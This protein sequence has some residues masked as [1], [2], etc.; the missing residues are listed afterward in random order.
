MEN[1]F[2]PPSDQTLLTRAIEAEAAA[3]RY[4]LAMAKARNRPADLAKNLRNLMGLLGPSI[5]AFARAHGQIDQMEQ[6]VAAAQAAIRAALSAST[7][8]KA[9]PQLGFAQRVQ[10]QL[11]CKIAA[12]PP[13]NRPL[14]QRAMHQ[15]SAAHA[16]PIATAH[17]ENLHAMDQALHL[18]R[19][20]CASRNCGSPLRE[21]IVLPDRMAN[22][23]APHDAP[24]RPAAASHPPMA[25]RLSALPTRH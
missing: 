23:P 19:K 6:V 5:L 24:T 2:S 13:Q 11:Q 4:A 7:S 1:A 22:P 9:C 8:R 18:A 20:L 17:A 25:H 16:L 10:W 3:M 21:P 14:H 12:L 15:Q